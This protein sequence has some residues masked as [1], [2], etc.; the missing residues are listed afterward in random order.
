MPSST[1]PGP[2][3]T[4]PFAK[5][6]KIGSLILYGLLGLA[7]GASLPSLTLQAESPNVTISQRWSAPLPELS[8]M[9]IYNSYLY[10]ASDHDQDLLRIAL[11]TK[12]SPRLDLATASR[13]RMTAPPDGNLNRKSQ[14]EAL[15]F[16][17]VG[18]LFALKEST[19]QIFQFDAEGKG[20]R[21]FDLA[22]W[23]GR[24]SK[25]KGYEGLV[26]LKKSHIVVALTKPSVL[27]E[28]GPKGESVLGFRPETVLADNEAFKS[29]VLSGLVPLASWEMNEAHGCQPSDLAVDSDGSLL[30]LLKD[31]SSIIRLRSLDSAKKVITVAETY[32]LPAEIDHAEG[33]AS[34]GTQGFLVAVDQKGNTNNVFWLKFKTA[35][36]QAQGMKK[37]VLP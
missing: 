4:K 20:Q 29:P 15:A 2:I 32:H 1:L 28:Y 10:L 9:A 26:L 31:C 27:I 33:L 21:V 25:V 19:N 16:D 34:L 13:L 11:D 23:E 18:T 17:R 5:S 37:P 36:D 24:K 3:L 6:T 7:L 14:W 12:V 22:K 30:A 8:G 35:S